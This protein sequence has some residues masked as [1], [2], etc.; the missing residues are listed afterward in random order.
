M[1]R[2]VLF[3]VLWSA[4][5]MATSGAR[6]QL[7]RGDVRLS[8]DTD[9]FSV[10]GVKVDPDGDNNT[11]RHIVFGI[12]PNQ[13]GGSRVTPPTPAT[14]LG[15]GIGYTI[16]RKLVL[17]VRTGLGVD[18]DDPD[19]GHKA[20]YLA[21]SLMPGLT[22]VPIG[23]QAKLF[24]SVAGIFQANREKRDD[25]KQR[26]LLGGFST[27]IGTLIFP[28]NRFSVDLGFFF[29]AR[30]GGYKQKNPDGPD[31]DLQDLRGLIRL[32]FSFWI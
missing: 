2:S 18:I 9:L 26:A 17:G 5:L 10:A 24:I 12:G 4:L 22:W 11:D 13:M 14:P 3:T 1:K 25:T 29:E 8:L 32:G 27:G 6:A 20:K 23:R 7:D 30:F 19:G 16:S 28:A 31:A 15:L 21:F